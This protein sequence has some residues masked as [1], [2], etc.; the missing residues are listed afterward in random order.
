MAR[1]TFS[2]P[3]FTAVME[4]HA[5]TRKPLLLVKD[6]G[7][8]LCCQ[9]P[10]LD[11]GKATYTCYAEGYSPED[12]P[13]GSDLY[14]K[15]KAAVGGDDFAE[16]LKLGKP[17]REMGARPGAKL[18]VIMRDRDFTLAMSPPASEKAA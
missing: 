15:C 12:A 3:A 14:D 4:A 5:R 7:I 10:N 18:L 2:G 1:L 8:Y 13:E 6:D 17:M 11:A 9:T 16:N